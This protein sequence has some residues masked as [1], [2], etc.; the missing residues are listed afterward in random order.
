VSTRLAAGVR[1]LAPKTDPMATDPGRWGH[2]LGNL[3]E[4]WLPVLDAAAP[5]SVLEIGAYAGDVTRILL[6]WSAESGARIVSID[7][8][9]QESLTQLAGSHPGLELIRATSLEA[10]PRLPAPDAVIVD[11]DHNYYTVSRELTLIEE[12]VHAEPGAGAAS[13]GADELPLIICH[14]AAWPHARRDVYYTPALIPQEHRQPTAEGG[15]LFPGDPGLHSGGLPYRSPAVR[16]GGP[17]NGVLSA[18]ED[19]VEQ[20]DDLRLAV[21]P[22]FF[23]LAVIWPRRAPWTQKVAELLAPWD[24]NSILERLEANR[25]LHL[26]SREQEAAHAAWCEER[27]ARKDALLRKLLE[28]KTFSVAVWL[29]RLRQAGEPAFTKEEVRELLGS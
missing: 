9:P 12:R 15:Y 29:S 13:R 8:D 10:L 22:A 19:F 14:D 4:L 18:I 3:A 11:G 20:R 25:V 27:G 5:G 23:G 17:H 7:P 26:A 16:E 28:S 6:D 21:V 1:R 24:G 2:S